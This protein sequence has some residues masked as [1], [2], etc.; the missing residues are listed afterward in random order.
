MHGYKKK[1]SCL[2]LA[3]TL[4][5]PAAMQETYENTNLLK[6]RQLWSTRIEDFIQVTDSRDNVAH[7]ICCVRPILKDDMGTRKM[8]LSQSYSDMLQKCVKDTSHVIHNEQCKML[9]TALRT[10]EVFICY[11]CQPSWK[12]SL[13][14]LQKL[15][16][17][18][19]PYSFMQLSDCFMRNTD[20]GETQTDKL[21]L[22]KYI[23]CTSSEMRVM[24]NG[25]VTETFY[26]PI[27][28]AD[29]VLLEQSILFFR[30]VFELHDC[31]VRE[32]VL[33]PFEMV[34]VSEWHISG[35]PLLMSHN[36]KS[37]D[38]R[39]A[40]RGT[41]GKYYWDMNKLESTPHEIHLTK[42]NKK[43][44]ASCYNNKK[45]RRRDVTSYDT[46]F[47]ETWDVIG[48]DLQ[49]GILFKNNNRSANFILCNKHNEMSLVSFKFYKAISL[50]FPIVFQ[51]KNMRRYYARIIADY[52][53]D[54]L[55]EQNKHEEKHTHEIEK[56]LDDTDDMEQEIM[57]ALAE[58]DQ[59]S[60]NEKD[61]ATTP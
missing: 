52:K 32:F 46:V 27:R 5:C 34:S 18:D 13:S 15:I 42:I 21:S 33:C 29:F 61:Q 8:T 47:L 25:I 59:S 7:C 28:R 54:L 56:D 38:L 1:F 31:N 60:D 49:H 41:I 22:L 3:H 36:K 19:I 11:I 24:K 44:C 30:H 17:I 55:N 39:K 51:Q 4:F 12:K 50:N 45:K 20:C 10:N 43:I 23:L 26:H 37:Q 14:Q 57:R 16:K 40:I 9:H 53:S 35:F 2:A 6:C 58:D 48:E